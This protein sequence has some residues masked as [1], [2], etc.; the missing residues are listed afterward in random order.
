MNK[1]FSTPILTRTRIWSAFA[2]AIVTD[3]IQI[4]TIPW[5]WAFLD[6]VVDVIAM[7]LVSLLVGFHLLF[8][9]T[10]AIKFIPVADVLP[11][12][13]GCVA[14]VVALRRKQQK[15]ADPPNQSISAPSRSDTI[16][17]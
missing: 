5:G 1:L 11:T 6:E 17:V 2:V 3:G 8:L 14:V 4:I 13:T 10:F 12:W 16:D 15:P 9:P 7:I